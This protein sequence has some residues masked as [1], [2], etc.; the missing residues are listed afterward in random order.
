MVFDVGFKEN[1]RI[2]L[3]QKGSIMERHLFSKWAKL[4]FSLVSIKT[5][6]IT[7]ATQKRGFT[8]KKKRKKKGKREKSAANKADRYCWAMIFSGHNLGIMAYFV[9]Y[10]EGNG[11]NKCCGRV[12]P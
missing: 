9:S 1:L 11:K 10:K 3:Q 7:G 2:K 8:T 12:I 4:C 5:P 6:S